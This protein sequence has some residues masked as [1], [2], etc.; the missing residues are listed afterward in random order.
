M[1]STVYEVW[2]LAGEDQLGEFTDEQ[3]TAARRFASV[4]LWAKTGR[5]F[6]VATTLGDQY[7]VDGHRCSGAPWTPELYD[8]EW[9]NRSG[10]GCC[11]IQ[12]DYQPVRSVIEVRVNGA[13]A[14]G[15]RLE[16][17][18]LVSV[19]RCW[20]WQD[21]QDQPPIEVDYTWGA[22]LPAGVD[23]VMAEVTSEV[24]N[25]MTGKACRLP[26][27]VQSVARQGVDIEFG[28]PLAF[29]EAGL[30]GTPL[31]DALIDMVNPS[32]LK[33]RSRVFS[34]DLGRR[35]G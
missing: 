27:R 30:L 5:R 3:I 10:R 7:R 29:I 23:A 2:P 20:P 35:A 25:A 22:T 14:T 15:W 31:A 9:Y 28:D 19:D 24:L 12:L 26:S 6:G 13:P 4:V 32:R 34:P 16:G 11:A 18:L 17:N 8:G 33:Y 1:R 21:F